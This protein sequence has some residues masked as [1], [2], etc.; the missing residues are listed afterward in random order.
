MPLSERHTNLVT[1][2]SLG[3]TPRPSV[4]LQT[5]PGGSDEQRGRRPTGRADRGSRR[6][7]S[8]GAGPAR[9]FLTG[10]AASRCPSPG[11]SRSSSALALLSPETRPRSLGSWRRPLPVPRLPLVTSA[12][13]RVD[14]QTRNHPSVLRPRPRVCCCAPHGTPGGFC[15]GGRPVTRL[16]N[17]GSSWLRGTTRFRGA[18]PG[19]G[20]GG[21]RGGGRGTNAPRFRFCGQSPV[22]VS[23]L[24]GSV[25]VGASGRDSRGRSG[26][27]LRSWL[28]T[29]PCS[30]SRP[31]Q[32]EIVST[33][34]WPKRAAAGVAPVRSRAT[35]GGPRRARPLAWTVPGALSVLLRRPPHPTRTVPAVRDHG[36]VVSTPRG[37]IERLFLN[38]TGRGGN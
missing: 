18:A 16:G 7:G 15:P 29:W 1:S 38:L 24:L 22:R 12:P 3:R 17:E 6:P 10:W 19:S 31:F 5:F 27:D 2:D 4:C 21:G 32:E 36:E 26:R 28:R 11:P 20:R 14:L 13:P 33:L 30:G 25:A 23:R 9:L 34:V 8:A 37:F 35:L